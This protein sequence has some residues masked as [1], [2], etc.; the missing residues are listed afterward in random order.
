MSD[1]WLVREKFAD[2]ASKHLAGGHAP[3]ACSGL[4]FFRLPSG[5]QNWQLH[6]LVIRTGRKHRTVINCGMHGDTYPGVRGASCL[7]DASDPRDPKLPATAVH[8]NL[9]H[10]HGF[11]KIQI[12]HWADK[13]LVLRS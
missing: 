11:D 5:Q 12:V 1:E 13:T 3:L 8:G 9:T 10:S 4:K 2:Y 6:D 7:S